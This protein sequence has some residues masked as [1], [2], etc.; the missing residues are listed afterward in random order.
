M[1]KGTRAND[2]WHAWDKITFYFILSK[3]KQIP[4][5]KNNMNR[6]VLK[7]AVLQM[8]W[9]PHGRIEYCT[10]GGLRMCG[11]QG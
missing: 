3:E 11:A 5:S 1:K 2:T 6:I 9:I 7:V 8:K 4:E 10:V